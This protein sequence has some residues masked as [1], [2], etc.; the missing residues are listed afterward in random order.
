M[1][2]Q[3]YWPRGKV[4]GGS[5]SIN[6]MVYVR[7]CPHD[8]DDWA[9]LGNPGWDFTSV[10]PWFKRIEHAAHGDPAWRGRDG[11]LTVT[12]IAADA[13]PLCRQFIAA[14]EAVGVPRNV[15]FN[16]AAFEGVGYF[17]N[18]VWHGRRTSSA[19]AWL[20]PA[21]RHGNLTVVTHARATSIDFAGTRAVSVRY[22][23][24]DGDVAM[25]AASREVV[26]CAGAV[27]TPQLLHAV[28]R[29]TGRRAAVAGHPGDRGSACG[30]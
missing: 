11:P 8:Y 5:G 24:G 22:R 4:L 20:R 26:L 29:R 25:A 21:R 7:G 23:T 28:G 12:D 27:N 13:H 18:S 14:G 1:D 19:T 15:D 3:G 10:L 9:A 6:A 17:E 16:G 30:G 2:R